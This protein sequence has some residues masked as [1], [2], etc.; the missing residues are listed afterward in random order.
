MQV[1]GTMPGR[2]TMRIQP[3]LSRTSRYWGR[4]A[5]ALALTFCLGLS[6]RTQ[7]QGQGQAQQQ[8]QG[9]QQ[10]Q[11]QQPDAQQQEP[12]TKPKYPPQD[13]DKPPYSKDHP[14]ASEPTRQAPFNQPGAEQPQP[15]QRRS[16]Q[17]PSQLP[18]RLT[19]PAG[20]I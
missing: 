15:D 7:E 4:V 8:A 11:P 18:D 13:A 2:P 19:I 17:L 16:P 10:T 3:A 6:A 5:G 14:I 12:Q 20:T 1:P 9:Q